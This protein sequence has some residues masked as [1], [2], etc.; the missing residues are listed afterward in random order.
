MFLLVVLMRHLLSNHTAGA[1]FVYVGLALMAQPC[2]ILL[3]VTVQLV[4]CAIVEELGGHMMIL[5]SYLL[6]LRDSS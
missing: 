4:M 2:A 1:P 5:C 6:K 3:A